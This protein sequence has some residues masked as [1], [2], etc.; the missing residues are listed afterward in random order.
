M[1]P[2]IRNVDL[3]LLVALDALYDERSVTRVAER[4]ALS[5]PTVSGMLKRLRHIFQDDLY[6][7][8][9]H[10]VIPTPRAEALARP[11]R[12]IIDAARGLLVQDSFDP[13]ETAFSVSMCGT[14]YIQSIILTTFAADILMAAPQARVSVRNRPTSALESQLSRGVFDL[15]LSTR[16]ML[17]PGLPVLPLFDDHVICLSSYDSHA[18]GQ[19]IPLKTFCALRHVVL[20]PATT[21]TMTQKIDDALQARGLQRRVVLDV[22]SFSAVFRAMEQAELVALIPRYLVPPDLARVKVLTIDLALPE[23]RICAFWHPRMTNDAKHIWLRAALQRSVRCALDRQ[24]A[25]A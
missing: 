8:T 3:N 12:D 19:T 6:I 2:N 1:D 11:T 7:R 21:M 9:S 15:V 24:A 13:A 16:D 18:D 23:V 4:L 25:P 22:P 14:D 10:G 20:T 5:Q 17:P